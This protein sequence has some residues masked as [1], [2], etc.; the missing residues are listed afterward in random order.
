[1]KFTDKETAMH[2]YYIENKGKLK[3]DMNKLLSPISSEIEAAGGKKLRGPENGKQE[4]E[5]L[6]HFL[7]TFSKRTIWNILW[8]AINYELPGTASETNPVI[9]FGIGTEE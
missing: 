8:S 6:R 5:E 9:Q 4:Y 2:A 7:K 3:K 1:M